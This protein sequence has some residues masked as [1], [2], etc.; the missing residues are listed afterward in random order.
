M[1]AELPDP[2]PEV[3]LPGPGLAER[4]SA[5]LES[6]PLVGGARDGDCLVVAPRVTAAV[7]EIGIAAQ[8]VDLISWLNAAVVWDTLPE[9]S[10]PSVMGSH[11]ILRFAHRVTL[12]TGWVLDATARQFRDDLPER[13]VAPLDEYL[14]Q[15]ASATGTAEVTVISPQ[16]ASGARVALDR[17]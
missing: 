16:R 11:K 15:L 13:W 6:I 1:T 2:T 5:A 8:T 7:R 12:A 10:P 14:Q 3:V 17:E 9:L 4:L